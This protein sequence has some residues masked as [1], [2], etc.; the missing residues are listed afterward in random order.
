[1][2]RWLASLAVAL[3][4]AA[5]CAAVASAD[6]LFEDPAGDN[7]GVAPDVTTV[8]VSNTADGTI[9]FRITIANYQTLP[10]AAQCKS[11]SRALPRSRQERKHGRVREG[12][13]G[14]LRQHPRQQ[15]GRQLLALGRVAD[16]RRARDEH[17]LEP[18]R[19]RSHVHDQP[20]RALGRDGIH[21]S[22]RSAHVRGRSWPPVRLC[23]R[24][25]DVRPRLPAAASADAFRDQARRDPGA[26]CRRAQVHRALGSDPLRL[27]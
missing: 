17:E 7:Q 23:R 18:V 4:L 11:S 12:G 10:P 19:G 5:L 14:D 20:E 15:R 13:R 22:H 26:P 8:E 6:E 24:P 2:K 9:T 3:A 27:G 25:V 16:G 1:M 21:F